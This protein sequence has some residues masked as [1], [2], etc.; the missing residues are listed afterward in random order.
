MTPEEPLSKQQLQ[1]E[2]ANNAAVIGDKIFTFLKPLVEVSNLFRRQ[3]WLNGELNKILSE[4][5]KPKAVP[6]IP[7]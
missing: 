5:N 6:K 7:D 2:Y 3:L 1:T 4:E